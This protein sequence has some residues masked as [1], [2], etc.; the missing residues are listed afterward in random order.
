VR[1]LILSLIIL[2]V[3]CDQPGRYQ[4]TA[5]RGSTADDDRVWVLDTKTGRVSMCY[6]HA[7][8]INCLRSSA[9]PPQKGQ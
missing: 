2:L 8:A 6:E 3:G 9:L 5:T 7:A 1:Y 4:I